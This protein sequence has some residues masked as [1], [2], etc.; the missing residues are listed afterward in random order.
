MTDSDRPTDEP[1]ISRAQESFARADAPIENRSQDR[2]NRG[3]LADAIADQVIYGPRGLGLV[4]GI[5]GK[6]GSGKTSILS[7]VE[8][9][10]RERS[11]TIVVA[12]NP[13]LFST[14]DQLVTRFLDELG[15]Q[16]RGKAASSPAGDLLKSAGD[17]LSTYAEAIEPLGWL[18][19]IGPWLLRFG[20]AGRTYKAVQKAGR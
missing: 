10:V 1:N 2:L 15:T 14:T 18:P 11:E 17:Q 8:Q 6:W 5:A 3:R 20:Y 16:L 9:S 7:M 12:F 4:I 19:V 13:W